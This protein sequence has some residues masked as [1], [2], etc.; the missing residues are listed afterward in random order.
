[1]LTT[2]SFMEINRAVLVAGFIVC[3]L[4]LEMGVAQAFSALMMPV[5]NKPSGK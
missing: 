3:A 2:Q 1:M 4:D 5:P